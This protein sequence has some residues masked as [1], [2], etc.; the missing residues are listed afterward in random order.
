M[1]PK[2]SKELMDFIEKFDYIGCLYI[3]DCAVNSV[4]QGLAFEELSSFVDFISSSN[5]IMGLKIDMCSS[6]TPFLDLFFEFA[7]EKNLCIRLH[8]DVHTQVIYQNILSKIDL[9]R[10]NPKHVVE[11]NC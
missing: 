6:E 1:T 5:N 9:I 3:L 10:Q 8:W 11:V 7:P 4:N 2:Y